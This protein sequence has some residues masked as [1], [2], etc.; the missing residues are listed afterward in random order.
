[1]NTPLI[2]LS[3]ISRIYAAGDE[4]VAA[5]QAVSLDIHAGEMVAIIGTSGSGKSTLMNILGCLDKPSTG[6]YRVAGREVSSLDGGELAELRREHF[7]FIFQR[8][9]L[10]PELSAIANVEMPAIYAG[11]SKSSRRARAEALLGRLGMRERASHRPGQLSGGQQQ[12]VSIAR[13]LMNGAEVIL[14]D[15]P[16]GALDTR[17]GEDV[18]AILDELNADGHTVI[19]VTHDAGVASRASRVIEIADGRVV[20]DRSTRAGSARTGASAAPKARTQHGY[21]LISAANEALHMALVAMWSHKMR[22]ALTMLGIIIGI[23]SV[24][25]VVAIGRGS[26]Q[27]IL[28]DISQLGTNTLEVFAGHGFG[29]VNADAITTL[30]VGDAEALARQPYAAAVTPT[31][32]LQQT[33]RYGATESSAFINGV[34]ASYFAATARQLEE[35]RFFDRDSVSRR[36]QDVVIDSIAREA[37]FPDRRES[38][39]GKVIFVGDVPLR[40]IGVLKKGSS[41]M[42]PSGMLELYIP[43]T[44]VQTRF[45]GSQSLR[46]IMVQVDDA[47]PMAEAEAALKRFLIQRHGSEDFN[48]FN[49]DDIRQAITSTTNIMTLLV[50]VIAVISLVVGGIGVMNIMLVSVSERVSEIGVRMAVGARNNDIL[51]QFLIEAA[52]V[53]LVGGLL[54][55]GGAL[56]LGLIFGVFVQ[57]VSL[58]YSPAS[59]VAAIA[60][61]S[62]IGI[63]FGFLP[64][65]NASKLDPVAALSG[66]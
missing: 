46:S 17:S 19:I 12:R 58:I 54:G 14:A 27:S 57:G 23:M 22:S 15:E 48:I 5:L 6:S 34:G 1:M 8:Y 64:A 44:S 30:T 21:S 47:Y 28:S 61:S 53:C 31:D 39:L 38:P 3:G 33:V 7:G 63:V 43:F 60:C 55:I 13:A 18:L 32:T 45:T 20:A 51:R 11:M 25:S 42:A 59:I 16:T 66:A 56:L 52:I 29:D 26:Q 2:S 36:S 37:L 9:H 35:G 50:A 40:V 65:R 10:L 4:T 49:T 41:I 24:V 62:L